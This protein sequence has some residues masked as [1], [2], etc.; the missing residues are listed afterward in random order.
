MGLLSSFNI[1]VSGLRSSGDSMS[2][3][4]DN[5]ANSGTTG[6][7]KSRAEFQD[8]LSKSLK[9]I[10]G[11]DQIGSGSK[12]AHIKQQFVQGNINR[13]NNIT[14]LALSGNGF[15]M[16]ETGFGTGFTRDGSFH[17]DKMGNLVNSDSFKIK[18][19][20]ANE[21]GEITNAIGPIKLGNTIIPAGA[22]TKVD[23]MMNLDSREAA[24][25]F[26]PT[27]PDDSSSYQT[28]ISVYDNV[29]TQRLINVYYNKTANN[30]WEYHAMVDGK[31]AAGGVEGTMVEMGKGK[32][33]FNAKGQLDDVVEELSAFNFNGGA[34]P[35]QKIEMAFGTTIKNGGDGIDGSTQ[36][37]A[38]SSISRHTADGLKAATLAS[39]SFSDEGILS[40]VYDNGETRDIAQI[41]VAKF[42]NNEGLFKVGKNMM[43]ESRKSG[44]GAAGKPGQ[45]GRGDVISKSLE[46]SNVDIA[47]EFIGLMNAQRNFQANTRTITTA[48][49]MLQE[50]L[51]IKR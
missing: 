31:D 35:N 19:F 49:E 13:T 42:E 4:G 12:L 24:K 26:D 6:F 1:G 39:L 8:L 32:I 44:Q 20:K 51:N 9:G 46:L 40:A 23:M 3:I 17:F 30:Q 36:Y 16:A 43:K 45:D 37:G 28:S 27:K 2:V 34:E 47:T 21:N 14:D 11:G 22:T 5:I 29:G 48:N 18:G 38:E 33:N 15:F 50:V 25:P 7:K 10:D 41:A